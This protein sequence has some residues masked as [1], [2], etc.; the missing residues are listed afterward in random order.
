M[1]PPL[2][3]SDMS[4][5][6]RGGRP[7]PPRTLTTWENVGVGSTSGQTLLELIA[8]GDVDAAAGFYDGRAPSVREYCLHLCP[9][10]LVDEATLAAF[11]DFLGRAASLAPD[12]DADDVVRR[13][14]RA[15]AAGRF[16]PHHPR[17]DACRATPELLAA[18]ANGELTRSDVALERHLRRCPTCWETAERLSEAEAALNGPGGDPPPLDVRIAWLELV[19]Q[20]EIAELAVHAGAREAREN[21]GRR[22]WSALADETREARERESAV[23]GSPSTA[24]IPSAPEPLVAAEP[25]SGDEETAPVTEPATAPAMPLAAP[26]QPDTVRV[27]ARRGGLVG[28][29][30]RLA[31]STRRHQ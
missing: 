27:R 20:E 12:A 23:E 31:S 28:A 19:G 8:A 15:A 5:E 11:A 18:R 16:D 2:G 30:K 21:G 24:A 14:A 7:A 13:A 4:W 22:G 26:S 10:E 3:H 25:P 1:V 9:P 29:A 6:G 17:S